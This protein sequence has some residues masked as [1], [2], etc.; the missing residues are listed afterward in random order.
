MKYNKDSLGPALKAWRE[1]RGWS[2]RDVAKRSE[3]ESECPF[4]VATVHK[5]EKGNNDPKPKRPVYPSF[6][7]LVDDILPAYGIESLDQFLMSYCSNARP[8]VGSI[9]HISHA[10]LN[11]DE[12][13]GVLIEYADPELL[14]PE[15]PFRIDI[16]TVPE[17]KAS[18]PAR[19]KGYNYLMVI[20]GKAKCH[21]TDASNQQR[22][23]E[24]HAG[25]A[26][27][28]HT[29]LRHHTE[30]VGG[31]TRIVVAR[32]TWGARPSRAEE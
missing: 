13:L 28:F 1:I 11:K 29:D 3:D 25:D 9:R 5:W 10:H 32:P 15:H 31:D 21:F 19:H 17:K 27:A 18:T 22:T 16:M 20:D 4:S 2:A 12:K 24:L 8:D 7:R 26:V 30:A 6:D 23:V 14:G